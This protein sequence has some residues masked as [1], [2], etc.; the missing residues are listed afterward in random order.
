M[1]YPAEYR[2]NISGIALLC[3]IILFSFDNVVCAQ[4][5]YSRI[6]DNPIAFF[7]ASL[8]SFFDWARCN[9]GFGCVDP[10]PIVQKPAQTQP[11]AIDNPKTTISNQPQEIKQATIVPLVQINETI[12]PISTQSEQ[13]S[14]IQQIINPTKEIQTIRTV[15]TNTQTVV[16]DQELRDQVA[17]L[18]HQMDSDRPNYSV[19]QS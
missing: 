13:Q 9:F 5:T 19:G 18:L 6:P 1:H 14:V 16:A 12:K 4:T 15:S 10:N 3:A 17:R 11:N 2:T 8:V 7:Q